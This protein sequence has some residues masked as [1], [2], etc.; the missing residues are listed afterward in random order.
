MSN[1]AIET[2]CYYEG[3]LKKGEDTFDLHVDDFCVKVDREE[4]GLHVQVYRKPTKG[5]YGEPLAQMHFLEIGDLN[6][7]P[8][9]S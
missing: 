4:K 2:P 9:H 6:E 1:S 8:H 7:T 5:Y 3:I